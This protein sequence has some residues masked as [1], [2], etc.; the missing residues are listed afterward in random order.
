MIE[1]WEGDFVPDIGGEGGMGGDPPGGSGAF[2][3]FPPEDLKEHNRVV[4][5][6]RDRQPAA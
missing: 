2:P 3:D 5:A 6:V 1:A 4:L